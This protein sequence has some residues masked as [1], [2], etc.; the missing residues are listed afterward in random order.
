MY[1][2]HA[3]SW[4][5]LERDYA[6]SSYDGSGAEADARFVN[7]NS[8]VLLTAPHAVNHHRDGHP[9]LA[10]RRTGGLAEL[11]GELT[12]ASVLSAIGRVPDW[13]QWAER[14]DPFARQLAQLLPGVDYVLDL[15]GMTDQHGRQLCIGTGANPSG[16][17]M[18][19][20]RHLQVLLAPFAVTLDDP[21]TAA[22]GH[23][24]VTRVQSLGGPVALQLE[25]TAALRDPEE[26]PELANRFV[27]VLAS[28]I[29]AIADR[30]AV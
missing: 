3:A 14:E 7:R 20:A 25:I 5:A 28:A 17:T 11:L 8:R 16:P 10:D 19:T 22:G 18:R 12:G 4:A 1:A 27:P 29:S 13:R 24:V 9:K 15:H 23:T 2:D 26:H 6:V 30:P 21:F